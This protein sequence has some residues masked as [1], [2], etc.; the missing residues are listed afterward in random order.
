MSAPLRRTCHGIIVLVTL[1]IAVAGGI[2]AKPVKHISE[3]YDVTRSVVLSPS[4]RGGY[5]ME[6]EQYLSVRSAPTP[7]ALGVPP[8]DREQYLQVQSAS[9]V[10]EPASAPAAAHPD[11]SRETPAAQLMPT[12]ADVLTKYEVAKGDTALDIANQFNLDINT[13]IWNNDLGEGNKIVIGDELVILPVDGI[14]HTIEEGDTLASI[15]EKYKVDPEVILK[16]VPNRLHDGDESLSTFNKII[17]PGGR[18]EKE[19]TPVAPARSLRS[20]PPATSGPPGPPSSEKSTDGGFIWPTRGPI[21][22]YFGRGHNGIDISPPY[23]TPIYA[24]AAGRVV[25]VNYIN[26]SYGWN[27][28]IDHGNG[29]KTHYSH[30]SEILVKVG[31]WVEQGQMVGR[32]GTTG[33]ATGPHLDFEVIRNGVFVDPL[34]YLP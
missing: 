21:F 28:Y 30:E 23:G 33:K 7:G 16:Y 12:V 29:F 32:V 34:R 17:V 5:R 8:I 25:E 31:D 15:G 9:S 27:F 13:L 3:T 14:L 26:Y 1:A 19:W 20:L 18:G 11:L 22:S 6:Q 24:A 2:S 10:D 4:S